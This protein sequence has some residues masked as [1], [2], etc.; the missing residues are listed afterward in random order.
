MVDRIVNEPVG[1]AHR[2]PAVMANQLERALSDAL[3][4]VSGVFP[5]DEEGLGLRPNIG[6]R[7]LSPTRSTK[8]SMKV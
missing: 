3:R 8:V 5:R 6:I 1:G 7:G 4:Q 2:D